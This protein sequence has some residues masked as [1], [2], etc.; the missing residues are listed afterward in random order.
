M[1]VFVL[2]FSFS[3]TFSFMCQ[4]LQDHPLKDN[5]VK[6]RRGGN[7]H[8]SADSNFHHRPNSVPC[9]LSPQ[10]SLLAHVPS[11]VY[12]ATTTISPLNPSLILSLGDS[13]DRRHGTEANAF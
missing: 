11:I 5:D 10:A 12:T 6:D 7:P 9:I 4:I 8:P 2:L 3:G 1:I 13:I